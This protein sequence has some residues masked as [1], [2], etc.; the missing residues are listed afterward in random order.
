MHTQL[1]QLLDFPLI[2]YLI[3]NRKVYYI[4]DTNINI[5]F[6]HWIRIGSGGSRQEGE[7][8]KDENE[9]YE[10]ITGNVWERGILLTTPTYSLVLYNVYKNGLI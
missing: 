1:T 2:K 3:E 5:L 9:I 7:K 4:K 8:S 10:I 6:K